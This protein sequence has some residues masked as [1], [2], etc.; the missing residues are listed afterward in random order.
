MIK[1]TEQQIF[2][3]KFKYNIYYDIGKFFDVSM[4]ARCAT[5]YFELFTNK[6]F[7]DEYWDFIE[8]PNLLNILIDNKAIYLN[9]G[10]AASNMVN[11]IIDVTNYIM[12][13]SNDDDFVTICVNYSLDQNN[14]D[15]NFERMYNLLIDRG[16]ARV[17]PSSDNR[18]KYYQPLISDTAKVTEYIDV[19]ITPD[20]TEF[21]GHSIYDNEAV[22]NIKKMNKYIYEHKDEIPKKSK[23]PS[24]EAK[25][26]ERI[27]GVYA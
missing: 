7:L 24:V 6:D 27:I 23:L 14:V 9:M 15:I 20:R 5:D 16:I 22:R 17:S 2:D 13:K 8:M 3:L 18:Y 12:Q 25:L 4:T 26:N 1:P 10:K 21:S 11:V 19:D